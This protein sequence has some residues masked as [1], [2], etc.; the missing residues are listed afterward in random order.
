MNY[1]YLIR[2]YYIAKSWLLA[3]D[4]VFLFKMQFNFHI[5]FK[6]IGSNQKKKHFADFRTL[7]FAKM[8]SIIYFH[9]KKLTFKM[10]EKNILYGYDYFQPI[11]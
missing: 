7:L 2:V 8:Y 3:A 6:K 4:L 9:S 10:N 5:H 11:M 1:L